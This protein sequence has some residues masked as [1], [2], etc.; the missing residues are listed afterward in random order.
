MNDISL[1]E[2]IPQEKN[3]FPV[4]ILLTE[5]FDGTLLPHWHEHIEMMYFLEGSCRMTCGRNT[6]QAKRG[7]LI[8]INSTELHFFDKASNINYICVILSPKMF[9]DIDFKDTF[10]K[11]LICSDARLREIFTAV[12]KEF[13]VREKG[14]DMA[15]KGLLYE[16]MTYLVRHYTQ[17][18]IRRPAG[19]EIM[20]KRI[21]E[22][23]EYIS[24]R[25]AEDLS[26]AE[27]AKKWYLS[28]YYFCRFFKNA[29][30]QSP[31][32][33]INRTRI[34]KAAVILENTDESVT[35]VSEKVGFDD[36]NYFSRTF[37]KYTGMSPTE[38]RKMKTEYI[39]K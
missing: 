2:Q 6:F 20:T 18:D 31:V 39:I 11:N 17:K 21:N 22:V 33:Y 34:E 25:Y 37:K 14:Y 8:F 35:V 4:R 13:L 36:V 9:A 30:G 23:L 12:T 10:I 38:F 24:R 16:L 7:D 5:G 15:I 3:G 32:N 27:L 28:E 26:T 29:T 19:N 1:Y